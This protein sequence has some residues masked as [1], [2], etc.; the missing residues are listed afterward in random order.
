MVVGDV[1]FR[2]M[3]AFDLP[4]VVAVAAAAG[5]DRLTADR[6][7]GWLG[8]R[9]RPNIGLVA[10]CRDPGEWEHRVLGFALYSVARGRTLLRRVA[11]HP[12]AR[13]GAVGLR[14]VTDV[15]VRAGDRHHTA[16][17]AARVAEGDLPGQLF[18]R[19]CGLVATRL[20]AAAGVVHF[21]HA[22]RR[23]G[24]LPAR[25]AGPAGRTSA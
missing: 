21:T 9:A 17:L 22:L 2:G 13:R 25:S 23:P 20:D 16:R 4:E 14:L 19:A 8:W 5:W 6:L 18:A 1:R 15:L 11:V 24:C 7:R 10:E 12:A 3:Q